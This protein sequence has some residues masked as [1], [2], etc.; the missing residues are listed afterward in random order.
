MFD[1][2]KADVERFWTFVDCKGPDDCWLWTGGGNPRRYGHFSIGPRVTAITALAHRVSYF[3]AYGATDLQVLHRCDVPRC[4]NPAHLFAG[5]QKV[6]RV[7]CKKKNRVSKGEAHGKSVHTEAEV[8]RVVD[9]YN[10]GY[11]V[12]DIAA[13][14]GLTAGAVWNIAHGK[15]WSWLTGVHNNAS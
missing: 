7:D 12:S 14:M 11:R 2:S 1:L 10:K 5:T 8:L 9:L 3:L 13:Q 4:V 6:N 15:C